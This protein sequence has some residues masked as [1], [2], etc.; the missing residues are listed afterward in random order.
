MK[1]RIVFLHHLLSLR[2]YGKVS[3]RGDLT[4]LNCVPSQGGIFIENISESGI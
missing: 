4:L 3:G 2:N 1:A